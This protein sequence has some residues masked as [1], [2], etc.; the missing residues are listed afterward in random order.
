MHD[1]E[2]YMK[3][4]PHVVLLGA[5]ASCAAIPSGDKNGRRISA[6][7][8]FIEKLG[9]D[10]IIS[11]LSLN[12]FS[13]NLEDVY[14]EMDERCSPGNKYEKAKNELESRIYRYMSE[15]SIPDTPTVYDFLLLSL[16]SKD[17]V[18]TFNWDPLLIQ[19]YQRV[20]K[21]H[22]TNLPELVFLHGN[23]AVGYCEADNVIGVSGMRCS[24]CKKLLKPMKLLY[25][26]RKKNYHDDIAI[27][28]SWKTLQN[29]MEVAYMVTIFGYSAPKSDVEAVKMLKEAWGDVNDRNLE[30]IEIIDLRAEEDVYHSW[31]EFIHS[32]HFSYHNDFFDTTL[33]RFPRRSC[34]AMFDMLMNCRFLNGEK[35][36]NKNMSFEDI[37]I[38]LSPL[39]TEECQAQIEG[40]VPSNPYF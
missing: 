27:S 9:L 3:S 28:K 5:G 14:M 29:A 8:G 24:K 10:S 21:W 26:I 7:S 13:D 33:G 31:A 36:F 2:K 25:P 6:M 37:S 4:R 30:E 34:E 20:S 12:T 40:R 18:A 17:L 35:G 19:A 38:F 22:T 1:I 11:G 32:H 16:T 15:F 39:L 23:V